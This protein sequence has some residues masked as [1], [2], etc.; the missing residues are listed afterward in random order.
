VSENQVAVALTS[1]TSMPTLTMAVTTRSS[2]R[3]CCVNFDVPCECGKR[4]SS[5]CPNDDTCWD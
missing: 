3:R 2:R 1:P 5:N 4:A